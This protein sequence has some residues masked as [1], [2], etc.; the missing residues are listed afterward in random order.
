MRVCRTG[1]NFNCRG[2]ADYGDIAMRLLSKPAAL[3]R[4]TNAARQTADNLVSVQ[5]Q[6][7]FIDLLFGPRA[8]CVTRCRFSTLGNGSQLGKRC[9]PP[10][11][12]Q[13]PNSKHDTLR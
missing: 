12:L 8:P 9:F 1:G 2:A 6:L 10:V 5:R 7:A 4:W 11:N 3:L 13:N